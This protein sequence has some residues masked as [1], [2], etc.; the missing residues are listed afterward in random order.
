MKM[1]LRKCGQGFLA[2]YVEGPLVLHDIEVRAEFVANALS[3]GPE[4]EEYLF[5]A[6]WPW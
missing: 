5:S 4:F 1:Y 3:L 6:G 2:F